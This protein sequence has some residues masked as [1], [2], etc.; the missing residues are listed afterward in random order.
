MSKIFDALR[1]AEQFRADGVADSVLED[2][3]AAN[4]SATAVGTVLTEAPAT[5]ASFIPAEA[6]PVVEAR[7]P[8]IKPP[9]PRVAALQVSALAP[10][11]PFEDLHSHA[12]EQYRMIRTKILHHPL[13]PRAIVVSS[14]TSGDGKTVTAINLA[15]VLAL[16]KDTRVL[17][18]D[19]DLRRR[20][21]HRVLGI[22]EKPGLADVLS[23]ATSLE[24]SIV[25]LE[26]FANLW[27]L[28]AGS[29]D[30]NPAELLE[31]RRWREVIGDCRQRFT[32]VVIDATPIAAVTDFEL[33]Q[34]ACDGVVLVVRP[35]HTNR[36]ACHKALEAVAKEK[37]IG[38][39][40]NC[41]EEW[42][43]WKPQGYGY[44][45]SSRA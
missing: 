15:A 10:V 3:I 45:Y 26:Q 14:P 2:A 42:F 41:V 13:Q 37:M 43:L 8:E 33:I 25:R 1:K 17:L 38:T 5:A 44:Y 9:A 16:K 29:G 34:L 27:V 19:A 7:L 24:E 39:V 20:D 21:V 36:G 35:D 22:P 31:S 12:A 18:V 30:R 11:F 40:L 23:G 4:S 28:P 32:H 6:E